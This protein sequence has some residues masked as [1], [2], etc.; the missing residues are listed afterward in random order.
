M[1]YCDDEAKAYEL[2]VEALAAGTYLVV[3]TV[4]TA[5]TTMIPGGSFDFYAVCGDGMINPLSPFSPITVHVVSCV[6]ENGYSPNTHLL[7]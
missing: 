3:L 6:H 5:M 4:T 1:D 7:H 2:Y